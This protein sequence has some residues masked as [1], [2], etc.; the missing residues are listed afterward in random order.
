MP[1]LLAGEDVDAVH[2][3]G[4]PRTQRR[5]AGANP[6]K[7]GAGAVE[8]ALCGD[9]LVEALVDKVD[10]Q[11]LVARLALGDPEPRLQRA[12]GQIRIGGL[13]GDGDADRAGARDGGGEVSPRRLAP[14]PRATED[15]DLPRRPCAN[16]ILGIAARDA[17]RGRDLADRG[18]ERLALG[19][20]AADRVEARQQRRPRRPGQCARLVDPRPRLREIGIASDRLID[21][22]DEERVAEA[23]PPVGIGRRRVDLR[24]RDKRGG[25]R[26]SRRRIIRADRAA[27]KR[28]RGEK[29]DRAHRAAPNGHRRGRPAR[30]SSAPCRTA[31]SPAPQRRSTP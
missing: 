25:Q 13:G 30:R 28:S 23:A 4:D 10:E 24:R 16:V 22:P 11:R 27:G 2:L 8:L 20:N 15:I 29:E 9:A 18:F 19:G 14:A 3:R 5:G 12:Q 26:K 21:Q 31:P 1:R 6:G 7:R 17:E